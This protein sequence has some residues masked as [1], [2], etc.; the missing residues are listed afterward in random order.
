MREYFANDRV[1][2]YEGDCIEVMRSLPDNSVDSI[3]TDPPVWIVIHGQGLG[4]R[5][6]NAWSNGDR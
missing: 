3:V 4:Q 1:T 6:Q 2:L 5:R